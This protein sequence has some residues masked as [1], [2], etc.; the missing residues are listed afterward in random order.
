M[1]THKSNKGRPVDM[2]TLRLKNEGAIAVGNMKV[3]AK[4]DKLGPGGEVVMTAAERVHQYYAENET[5]VT[6]T[7]IKPNLDEDLPEEVVPQKKER[8]KKKVEVEDAD[9]NIEVFD[10]SNDPGV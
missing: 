2:E 3:N 1:T 5:T 9:G 4:G 8:A 10:E 7:S 6:K